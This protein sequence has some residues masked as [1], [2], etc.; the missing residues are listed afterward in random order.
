MSIVLG[1]YLAINVG[2][3]LRFSLENMPIIFAG[4]A[5]GP[6]AGVLVG[7]ISDIV[8]SLMVGFEINPIITVGAGFI[9]LV[10]GLYKY[11]TFGGAAFLRLGF[12]VGVAHIIGSVIIKTIGLSWFYDTPFIILLLW[13]ALNY[14]IV[15]VVEWL[16]LYKLLE[17]KNIKAELNSLRGDK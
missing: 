6:V 2:Q 4:A 9:G 5:F 16:I 8:G 11:I 17:N 3:F 13:R 14:L 10:A 7:V 15:A 12:S 1:K